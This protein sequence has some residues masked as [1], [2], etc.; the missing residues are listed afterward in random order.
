M[1]NT[2]WT[3][4]QNVLNLACEA[5]VSIRS[6]AE[7]NNIEYHGCNKYHTSYSVRTYYL[8]WK[9]AQL[10][11]HI[12]SWVRTFFQIDFRRFGRL[13]PRLPHRACKNADNPFR[14]VALCFLRR[15]I[16]LMI[17]IYN[18]WLV[19]T[20]RHKRKVHWDSGTT[21]LSL[22]AL[23]PT[24]QTKLRR[25]IE[26]AA[27]FLGHF[28]YTGFFE[29]AGE[30]WAYRRLSQPSPLRHIPLST[31]V[32]GH[33]SGSWSSD[34]SGIYVSCSVASEVTDL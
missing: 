8:S 30:D 18:G 31:V 5:L 19:S 14:P 1:L 9:S 3:A 32:H 22:E 11:I 13:T 34:L 28:I 10:P 21:K 29:A 26:W 25:V 17:S 7:N 23:G 16:S 6:S 4:S 2:T 20:C 33:F 12:S 15:P 27:E 24:F